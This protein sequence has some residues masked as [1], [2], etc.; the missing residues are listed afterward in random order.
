MNPKKSLISNLTEVVPIEYIGDD[1][2]L[3][4]NGDITFLFEVFY[5]EIFSIE[6]ESYNNI[7][8]KLAHS[9]SGSN[10]DVCFHFMNLTYIDKYEEKALVANYT[11][12]KDDE[13][14]FGRPQLKNKN[15]LAVSFPTLLSNYYPTHQST[16]F[17][18]PIELLRA[19]LFNK[20]KDGGS[21]VRAEFIT[22]DNELKGI[23]EIKF[24][25][26]ERTD[27][28]ELLYNVYNGS[29]DEWEKLEGKERLF[30]PVE[31][32]SEHLKI[33]S[34]Y[35]GVVSFINE[36]A[37]YSNVGNTQSLDA[38]VFDSG[39]NFN[40]NF[41]LPTS[42]AYP[43]SVGMPMKH[44]V[45]TIIQPRNPKTLEEQLKK[46]NA[47]LTFLRGIGDADAA[48]K[49]LEI[50]G[51]GNVQGYIKE[52]VGER[53][54]TFS[55]MIVVYGDNEKELKKNT[56]LAR[57]AYRNVAS[58]IESFIENK[59]TANLYFSTAI[60]IARE[61]FMYHY[62]YVNRSLCFL[63]CERLLTNDS[64]GF[65]F[66]DL[67]G[68]VIILNLKKNNET[69]NPNKLVFG[70]SGTGKS[71]LLNNYHAQAYNM[72]YHSIILDVGG[73]YNSN[74]N[75]IG[76]KY[77]DCA[78]KANMSF[79]IF[80]CPKNKDGTYQYL[81]SEEDGVNKIIFL[82]AVVSKIL[83]GDKQAELENQE[84]KRLYEKSFEEYYKFN[85]KKILIG[86]TVKLSFTNYCEFFNS[87]YEGLKPEYQKFIDLSSFNL[88][89][90]PFI[91]GGDKAYLLN[92]EISF[93]IQNDRFVVFDVQAIQKDKLLL[94]IVSTIVVDIV[95]TKLR[96]L[97][98]N[99]PKIFT[100]DEA[101]DFLQG[102]S[103]GD[104]ISGMFRKIRKMGGEIIIATQDAKFIDSCEQLVKD[105]IFSNSDYK[106][107]L[108]LPS[109]DSIKDARR[110]M[111]ITD[112]E[113][114]LIS[115]LKPKREF[116]IKIGKKNLLL[117]NEVSKHTLA[118]FTTDPD[119]LGI[120]REYQKKYED[121]IVGV[122]N[123]VED[124]N[125]K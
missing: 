117:K 103:M 89:T 1:Y 40:N 47:G 15:Y 11:T 19:D 78:V 122:I 98:L 3:T 33:G 84:N 96:N 118:T 41:G 55:Q 75:I 80:E 100:I 6:E 5:P 53:A 36:P 39:I 64:S 31:V 56:G 20:I 34:Q 106:I 90:E 88:L 116:F 7:H 60:G 51:N 35:I 76:G 71:V 92:G 4:A 14:F 91:K 108:G 32:T 120:I 119:E 65:R 57:S 46:D 102:K 124:Q 74:C 25:K 28:A 109:E 48:R 16:S 43:I 123:Y 94:S 111:G 99:V 62:S 115:K 113:L 45:H 66:V 83:Y 26:L 61:N 17:I 37:T 8:R 85:N 67:F 24:K 52:I 29:F 81:S 70:P 18:K 95:E 86:E 77:I 58:G 10:D 107:I 44:I 73:S 82:Y 27:I 97:P 87:F 2:I 21:R 105:S 30:N 38:E 68:N 9:I 12:R 23:T 112:K 114:M 63:P 72:G 42:I 121:P 49:E 69:T 22:L 104:F 79:F 93:N 13:H 125:K 110:L 101:L 50:Y 54:C 59:Q